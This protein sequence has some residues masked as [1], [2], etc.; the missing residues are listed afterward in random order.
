[1]QN[2]EYNSPLNS[3]YSSEKMKYIFSPDKKFRTW[4]KLWIALAESE[5]ELGLG[6]TDE[7]ISEL[8]AHAED[9]DYDKAAEY[10]RQVR[11]DVMAHVKAYGDLCPNAKGIIHLGAT[12]CYVG[13]NTDIILMK[14]ALIQIRALLIGAIR[15]VRS[16]ADKYSDTPT[17]AYTHFQA[18]QPTTIGKRATL[19]A[20][21]LISD[22]DLVNYQID[23][24]K[25][26]GC[27]GTT[28]TC[29]SFLELFSGDISKIKELEKKIAAKMGFEECYPVSGQT[30]SRKVD[31]NVVSVLCSIAQ[32]AAKFSNDIR[33]LSHLKEF[34]EPFESGQI[35]SSAMAYK[36]NPMR[37]E[38]IA[39]LAR[40][41]IVDSL[42][43]AITASAQWFERTLDD[44]ANKRMSVPEAFLA[45]DAILSLYINIISNGSV[46]PAIAEK[47][48]REELPFMATENIMMYCVK[49]G[50]DRQE[51]HE[52]IRELSVDT[53]KKI[54]LGGGDNDLIE[55][56][57]ADERFGISEEEIKS[58][59]NINEFVGIAPQ[60]T[61]DFIKDFMDPVLEKYSGME[62][63]KVEIKV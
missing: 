29:A 32:S 24:L 59:I 27:K 55:K 9:I 62:D 49:K 16:F 42:N 58:L 33:L 39:S 3:R 15:A 19:W 11:H 5:K 14:E 45:T 43:P 46:Y 36:R 28:G 51:I 35:G 6:I 20:Q 38:R 34:D 50:K 31:Y 22:L 47:H 40:Y 63:A 17:L 4:R 52:L 26:L 54:K 7:Q 23:H 41:I 25:L 1:M 8:K 61:K 18:A 48:L 60:Q 12:S 44:S 21:D 53:A 2:N 56:I 57:T 30:Y 10:E 37:S 13:D